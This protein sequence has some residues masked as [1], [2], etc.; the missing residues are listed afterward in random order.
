MVWSMQEWFVDGL[1]VSLRDGRK[2]S[3][4]EGCQISQHS[5]SGRK[6]SHN[7]N[8]DMEHTTCKSLVALKE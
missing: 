8:V 6:G 2:L 5:N 4:K 3:G 7:R 1:G